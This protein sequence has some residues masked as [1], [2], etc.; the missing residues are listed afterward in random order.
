MR[1]NLLVR[2]IAENVTEDCG[3]IIHKMFTNK[4]GIVEP[5]NLKSVYRLGKKEEGKNPQRIRPILV[6]LNERCQRD[7]VRR[8]RF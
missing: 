6:K 1:D 3:A 7:L 5:L 4:L 8:I 2:G